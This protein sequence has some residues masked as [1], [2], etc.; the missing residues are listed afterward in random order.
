MKKHLLLFT[1]LL[2]ALAAE[3]QIGKE[4]ICKVRE[5]NSQRKPLANVQVIFEDAPAAVSQSDGTVRLLF[6]NRKAGEWTFKVDIKR[7]GYELV[8]EKEV[9][10]VKLSADKQFG[11]DIILARTG[12]V[13]SIKAIY[14]GVS[15]KS[16]KAGFERE[17]AKL[18]QARDAAR[19]SADKYAEQLEQLNKSFEE[20]Q[21]NLAALS[22]KFARVNFDDVD[23][24]YQEALELFQA[25]EVKLAI[26]KLEAI[27]PAKRTQKI[28]EEQKRLEQREAELKADRAALEKEKRQ[29]IT[30]LRLLAD[31]Y[32]ATFDPAKAENQYDQLL[33]L[34]STDLEILVDAARFYQNNHRYHKALR[35]YPLIIA[36]AKTEDWQKANAFGSMGEMQTA[37]GELPTALNAYTKY[38]KNY[39]Q[40][41][42]SNPNNSF[43][44]NNLAVAYEKLGDTHRDLGNLNQALIFFEKD[45][46][47]SK[48]L[49]EAFPLNVEFKNGLAVAYEKLGSTYI[50][51]GNLNQALTFFEKRSQLGKEL[52][53]AFPQNVEFKNGFAIAYEKLGQTHSDLGNLIQAL[54]FFEKDIELSKELHETFPQNVA[55]KHGL[56]I[57]YSKLGDTH[58]ALG[59][60]IQALSFFEKR[61]QLSKELHEAFPQNV[62]FKNSLAL[63]YEKL[64]STHSVLGN[65]IQALTFFEQY[66]DLEKELYEAFPQNVEFKDNLAI[67]YA[68]IG[69]IYALNKDFVNAKRNYLEYEKLEKELFLKDKS[70]VDF[71][72]GV[73]IAN[74]KLGMALLGLNETAQAK[75]YFQISHQ[76]FERLFKLSPDNVWFKANYYQSLVILASIQAVTLQELNLKSIK[77]GSEKFN[78][79]AV[80]TQNSDFLKRGEIIKKI[81][82]PGANIK[83]LIIQVSSFT[84]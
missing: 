14:Y 7:T 63:S 32:S 50:A 27:D 13:D 58:S 19:L 79:I 4:Q 10:K 78:E 26:A 35:T 67:S 75:M 28:I 15:N 20:Q 64:G 69:G 40:L 51:L 55:F 61:S 77:E 59:N 16:L 73:A 36:H 45:I 34:D 48:E 49:H 57:S 11:V 12:V 41:H 71:M 2:C 22:E 30:N 17:K 80:K 5:Q 43:Y 24:V 9:E 46:E 81:M 82:E 84:L 76:N 31:M 33:R 52:Y 23:A 74:T 21:N 66:N 3:A 47:L 25:G 1:L 68:M 65:L 72:D 53:E 6:Q 18:R 62:E 54:T 39:K 42:R 44:K 60:L 37:I 8:N 56:A 70:N 29:Q 83:E 38:F